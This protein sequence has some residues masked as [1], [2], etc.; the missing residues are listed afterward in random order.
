MNILASFLIALVVLACGL[1]HA[2]ADFVTI[3]KAH[4]DSCAQ[5]FSGQQ[6]TTC[7]SGVLQACGNRFSRNAS[8]PAGVKA[9]QI[10]QETAASL[11][12][13]VSKPAALS[14]LN[15]A[16]SIA[17]GLAAE[18]SGRAREVYGGLSSVF[19]RAVEVIQ[20]KG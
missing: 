18:S 20:R 2:Q 3:D 10:L 1:T 12:G 11:L 15:R 14:V 4:L 7:V 8:T 5:L 9:G 19:A 6:V 17:A 16:R 13:G